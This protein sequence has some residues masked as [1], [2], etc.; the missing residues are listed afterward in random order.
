MGYLIKVKEDVFKKFNILAL[1][2]A[3]LPYGGMILNHCAVGI[4]ELGT[5]NI[6]LPAIC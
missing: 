4:Y 6:Q 3:I 2:V 1:I 5:Q